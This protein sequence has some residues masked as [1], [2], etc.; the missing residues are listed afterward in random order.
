M[1]KINRTRIVNFT[2]NNRKYT[3]KT[4]NLNGDHTYSIL[5]NG[6]GKTCTCGFLLYPFMWGVNTRSNQYGKQIKNTYKT[7]S[8]SK[9]PAYIAHEFIL[10]DNSYL[11]TVVGAQKMIDTDKLQSFAIVSHYS[12]VDDECSLSNFPFFTKD[13]KLK[14]PKALMEEFS[15]NENIRCFSTMSVHNYKE[16]ISY[17]K[18]YNIDVT[19]YST[20]LSKLL[21]VEFG[22]SNF[23]ETN[24]KDFNKLWDDLL[25]PI[26]EEKAM[27]DDIFDELIDIVKN[28]IKKENAHQQD[29]SNY[30]HYLAVVS[31]LNDILDV[32]GKKEKIDSD[33]V[34]NKKELNGIF[35]AL[36]HLRDELAKAMLDSKAAIENET[37]VIKTIKYE[38][39]SLNLA[40]KIKKKETLQNEYSDITEKY[41]TVNTEYSEKKKQVACYSAYQ[42]NELI[43]NKQQNIEDSKS[44]LESKIHKNKPINDKINKAGSTAYHALVQKAKDLSLEKDKNANELK[45]I[46]NQLKKLSK[47]IENNSKEMFKLLSEQGMKKSQIEA[48]NKSVEA[49]SAEYSDFD[50]VNFNWLGFDERLDDYLKENQITIEKLNKE[51]DSAAAH[52]KKL[53]A[54][55]KLLGEQVAEIVEKKNSLIVKINEIQNKIYGFQKDAN[56]LTN[57][58]TKCKYDDI[59]LDSLDYYYGSLSRKVSDLSNI[60]DDGKFQLHTLREYIQRLSSGKINID[61]NLENVLKKHGIEYTNG[62][63]YLRDVSE[64][65]ACEVYAA[66]PYILYAVILTQ[67]NYSKLTRIDD[68]KELSEFCTPIII[69]E[70]LDDYKCDYTNCT[71]TSGT[72]HLFAGIPENAYHNDFIEGEIGRIN[73]QIKDLTVAVNTAEEEKSCFNKAASLVTMFTQQYGDYTYGEKKEVDK[74][75]LTVSFNNLTVKETDLNTRISAIQEKID[76]ETIKLNT[77]PFNIEKA[78]DKL[79]DLTA[80]KDDFN[81]YCDHRKQFENI[82]KQIAEKGKEKDEMNAQ[83][84]L[85]ENQKSDIAAYRNELIQEIEKTNHGVTKFELYKDYEF[86]TIS[87]DDIKR[88]IEQF[89]KFSSFDG[90]LDIKRLKDDIAKEIKEL[91]ILQD[92]FDNE[93]DFLDVSE[94]SKKPK[95]G[96][97]VKKEKSIVE[98]LKKDKD[99][100]YKKKTKTEMNIISCTEDIEKK[101]ASIEKEYDKPAKLD[102]VE[103]NFES[104]ISAHE[105]LQKTHQDR[106]NKLVIS[107]GSIEKEISRQKEYNDYNGLEANES[108]YNGV[109]NAD[110]ASDIIDK[111]R[112]MIER[113]KS[114]YYDINKE[115]KKKFDAMIKNHIDCDMVADLNNKVPDTDILT[116]TIVSSFIVRFNQSILLIQAGVDEIQKGKDV[117]INK[118]LEIA[119]CLQKSIKT[120]VSAANRNR[121]NNE[122]FENKQLV[123]FKNLDKDGYPETLR[124]FIESIIEDGKTYEDEMSLS[125]LLVKQLTAKNILKNYLD[126]SNVQ[127]LIR[128]KDTNR[129]RFVDYN[130]FAQISGSQKLLSSIFLLSTIISFEMEACGRTDKSFI[131]IQDNPF[132]IMNY[133]EYLDIFFSIVDHYDI[134]LWSWAGTEEETVL[135]HH[136]HIFKLDVVQSKNGELID[137]KDETYENVSETINSHEILYRQCSLFNA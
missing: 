111:K 4:F 62:L 71:I 67:K 76:A 24:Y 27:K 92:N 50:F 89:K 31:N 72:L 117:I 11:L 91:K 75:K 105:N 68:A 97:N 33:I 49:L 26:I 7:L 40:K 3:D 115:I 34:K 116:T 5:G 10:Q 134:Q 82:E 2:F 114:E 118:T 12:S 32:V 14:R 121:I 129:W 130:N 112:L 57:T 8:E 23:F 66:I 120:L 128:V 58:L 15:G 87:A 39:D 44:A 104:E 126:L 9:E 36:A 25:V 79:K 21:D 65:R 90:S 106:Y 46:E 125:N 119:N 45:N 98:S 135:A 69:K 101:F 88:N 123:E 136:N 70:N 127:L 28:Q 113:L 64:K 38:K 20:I 55:N 83:T 96:Y 95:F 124:N 63:Q 53:N 37:Q 109:I 1:P 61:K 6:K 35:K 132:S 84:K 16:Y 48:F 133:N 78:E 102:V 100:L 56:N 74:D 80:F 93:F 59:S 110:N 47:D 86:E 122:L 17:L 77:L 85:L 22:L 131:L 99:V 42:A 29:L 18:S 41:N 30:D 13:D 43:K 81:L 60:I 94:Y 108:L 51:K 103:R 19:L 54:D 137:V 52:L 107:H 73:K